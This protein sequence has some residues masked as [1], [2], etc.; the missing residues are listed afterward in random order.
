MVISTLETADSSE[1]LEV[2]NPVYEAVMVSGNAAEV[3]RLKLPSKSLI[4]PSVV[5]STTTLAPIMGVPFWSD[6]VPDITVWD[7]AILVTATIRTS[8]NDLKTRK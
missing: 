6:I 3:V 7:E 4:T 8:M 5:P 2:L 1:T